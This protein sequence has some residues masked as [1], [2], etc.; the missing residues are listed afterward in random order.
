MGGERAA[1]VGEVEN[2]GGQGWLESGE[3]ESRDAALSG[4]VEPGVTGLG[5][6][7]ASPQ[8]S[9]GLGVSARR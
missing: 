4:R 1:R 3:E 2:G 6:G 7:L 9:V 5:G 8:S